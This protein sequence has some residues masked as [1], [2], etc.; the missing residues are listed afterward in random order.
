MRLLPMTVLMTVFFQF[1]SLSLADVYPSKPIRW[2][3]PFA[4]GGSS[5]SSARPIASLLSAELGQQVVI[6]NKPGAGAILGADFVAKAPADGYTLLLV[7]GTHTLGKY[8]SKNLP[9][10]PIKD[11]TPVG[12]MVAVPYVLVTGPKQPFSNLMEMIAYGNQHGSGFSFGTTDVLGMLSVELLK[13]VGQTK[14]V[15]I[16]YKGA[17]AIVNDVLGGHLDSGA[18]TPPVVKGFS[19]E[20]NGLRMLAIT[21]AKRSPSLPDVPTVAELTGIKSF[22]IATWYGIAGPAG[23]PVNVVERLEKA[24]IKVMVDPGLKTKL[25]D[26]GVDVIEDNS[27]KSMAATM[28]SNFDQ[29]GKLADKAGIK[30]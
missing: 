18:T 29:W 23:M 16:N 12:R 13:S 14:V 9:Y 6:E 8:L 3:V 30:P 5:D 17:P 21:S 4:P 24:L 27:A 10:D 11:F 15:Q 19:K 26:M 2:I 28:R 7:P 25:I 20:K 1:P 22:E